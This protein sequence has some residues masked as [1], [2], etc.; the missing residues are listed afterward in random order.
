MANPGFT[1]LIFNFWFHLNICDL[2]DQSK[3]EQNQGLLNRYRISNVERN[4][5]DYFGRITQVEG[6]EIEFGRTRRV[7]I[8]YP[9]SRIETALR[10]PARFFH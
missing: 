1:F 2:R 8:C 6:T 9:I 5:V 10:I 7:E 4:E 3:I